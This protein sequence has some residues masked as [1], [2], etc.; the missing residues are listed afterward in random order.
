FGQEDPLGAVDSSNLYQAFGANYAVNVDPRGL[1][2]MPGELIGPNPYNAVTGTQAHRKWT[3]WLRSKR[4]LGSPGVTAFSN[5]GINTILKAAGRPKSAVYGLLR[6]D[7][8][9]IERDP[10]QTVTVWELKP[11]SYDPAAGATMARR[12]EVA[13][14]LTTYAAALLPSRFGTGVEL[15]P[16]GEDYINEVNFGGQPYA[17]FAYTGKGSTH[18]LVYYRLEKIQKEE[19]KSV[20]ERVMDR[21]TETGPC[22]AKYVLVGA[23][24]GAAGGAALGASVGAAGGTFVAPGVGTVVGAG[25]GAQGGAV[26]GGMGGSAVGLVQ[27]LANCQ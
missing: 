17:M 3:D 15:H 13:L 9:R 2:L 11:R 25:G 18:G 21:V 24:A 7:A 27:G 26:I 1:Q 5:N 20:A 22:V 19:K 23:G 8:A 4:P 16:T 10:I 14:Q 12:T 6:P